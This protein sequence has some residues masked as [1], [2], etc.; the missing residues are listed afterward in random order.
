VGGLEE[1]NKEP[2]SVSFYGMRKDPDAKQ[3]LGDNP[4][5]GEYAYF[6]LPGEQL[7]FI[8]PRYQPGETVYIKEPYLLDASGNVIY[9]YNSDLQ[10]QNI[11]RWKN[12]MFMPAR[13]ARYFIEIVSARPER[14]QDISEYDAIAE[15]ISYSKS[16]VGLCCWD[17]LR[18]GY[19]MMT[20]PIASYEF[21]WKSINGQKSW[22]KNPWVWV[23]QFN[24]RKEAHK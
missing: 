5:V 15:G 11:A 10:M 14:L 19:N 12:K 22:D 13:H 24:L 8:K 7:K 3:V 2:D 17:Y 23:Y 9:Y 21:L 1:V 20:T 16:P 4:L 18:G 6:E